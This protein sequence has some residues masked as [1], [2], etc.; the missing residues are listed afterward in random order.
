MAKKE[1]KIS[2]QKKSTFIS[3][4]PGKGETTKRS[5]ARSTGGKATSKK[6]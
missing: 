5:G 4:S 2:G 1:P 3:D 6:K